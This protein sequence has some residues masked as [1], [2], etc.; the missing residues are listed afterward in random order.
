MHKIRT[1]EIVQNSVGD[2]LLT[3]ARSRLLA[4]KE[5]A[6]PVCS[7]LGSHCAVMSPTNPKDVGA[8]SLLLRLSRLTFRQ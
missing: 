1:Q 7:I 2:S 3:I 6:Q 8:P 5:L 4:T